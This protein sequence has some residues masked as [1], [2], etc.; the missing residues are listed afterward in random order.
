MDKWQMHKLDYIL[1][2]VSHTIIWGFEIQTGHSI[3]VRRSDLA[4][5]KENKKLF[6]KKILQITD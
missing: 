2:N 1:D 4:L 3:S 5:I 6:I